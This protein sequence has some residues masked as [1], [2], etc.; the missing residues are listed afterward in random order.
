MKKKLDL[1]LYPGLE[2]VAGRIV[3]LRKKRDLSQGAAARL[4]G[5]SRSNLKKIEEGKGLPSIPTILTICRHFNV[6]SDSIIFGK[7]QYPSCV[8]E[9]ENDYAYKNKLL[10][11]APHEKMVEPLNTIIKSWEQGD[12]NLKGWIL[13]ELEKLARQTLENLPARRG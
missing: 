4:L 6:S 9:D 1:S 10:V 5:L 8:R 13:V 3:K 11:K 7:T 12:D 2:E